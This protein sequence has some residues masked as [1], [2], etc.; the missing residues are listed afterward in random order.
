MTPDPFLVRGLGLGTRLVRRGEEKGGERK[1][2][3][4]GEEER[5]KKGRRKD[6]L[7]I[8]THHF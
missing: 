6:G 8:N 1:D 2:G 3:M 7:K 5:R 4:K